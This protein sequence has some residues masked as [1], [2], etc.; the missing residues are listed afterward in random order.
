MN[1]LDDE[2][3]AWDSNKQKVIE[4][5]DNGATFLTVPAY[6][7]EGQKEFLKHFDKAENQLLNIS[8]ELLALILK[9][10]TIPQPDNLADFRFILKD[11]IN[12]LKAK[13]N[14]LHYP[15]AV[16]DKLCFLYA[17]VLDEFINYTQWGEDVSWENKTLLSELF[18][19]RNGGELFYTVTEKALRQPQKMVDLLEVIYIFLSIGFRGKYRDLGNDDL[20]SITHQLEQVISIYRQSGGLTSH[21]KT[22][23]P[24]IRKPTRHKKFFISTLI[25]GCL[26]GTAIVVTNFWYQQSLPQRSRDFV[27]LEDYSQKYVLSNQTAD[28][29]FISDDEDLDFVSTQQSDFTSPVISNDELLSSWTV[30]LATFNLQSESVSFVENLKTSPFRPTIE[31]FKSYFRVIIRADSREEA[32]NIQKWYQTHE[33]V[34]SLIIKNSK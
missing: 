19:M 17:V 9:I 1:Y 32:N 28:I 3:I 26:V 27:F 34:S 16:I 8:S 20:K 7:Q 23:L 13:G 6:S 5:S 4:V 33:S 11:Q 24:T 12:S 30:Q 25:F 29:V 2:T 10:K 18:G 31:E 21:I 14:E 22:N 15:V